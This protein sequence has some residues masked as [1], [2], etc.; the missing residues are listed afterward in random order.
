MYIEHEDHP[1]KLLFKKCQDLTRKTDPVLGPTSKTIKS[2]Q[3]ATISR[4]SQTVVSTEFFFFAG[5]LYPEGSYILQKSMFCL[6]QMHLM[7]CF[8]QDHGNKLD[9]IFLLDGFGSG[10][11]IP[12]FN[13]FSS[14][15]IGLLMNYLVSQNQTSKIGQMKEKQMFGHQ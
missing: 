6:S 2:L 1:C 15:P 13:F 12:V 10:F 8:A 11:L 14:L 5:V 4:D 3:R 9:L 7:T